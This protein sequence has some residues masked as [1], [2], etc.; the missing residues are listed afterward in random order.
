MFDEI[1]CCHRKL[2]PWRSW[3]SMC[4]QK[5]LLCLLRNPFIFS[6]FS[7]NRFHRFYNQ[8]F[9]SFLSTSD[10]HII[11]TY[12]LAILFTNDDQV[13]VSS[14]LTTHWSAK[15]KKKH[16][17]FESSRAPAATDRH[18]ASQP[19]E[20]VRNIRKKRPPM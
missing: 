1:S 8:N 15:V 2:A 19:P 20:G 3:L 13:R 16:L 4:A 12:C 17:F 9:S 6:F 5:T 10:Q 14:D 11:I 7:F 18:I